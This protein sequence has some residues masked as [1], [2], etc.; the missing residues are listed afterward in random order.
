MI[1][2]NNNQA[3]PMRVSLFS[4]IEFSDAG[5]SA[6]QDSEHRHL[7][8]AF[9]PGMSSS[10]AQL[11]PNKSHPPGLSDLWVRYYQSALCCRLVRN[12]LYHQSGRCYLYRPSCRCYRS[13]QYCPYRQLVRSHRLDQLVLFPRL[14]Q[15]ARSRRYCLSVPSDPSDLKDLK[16][17]SVRRAQSVPY[18]R[19]RRTSCFG[20]DGPRGNRRLCSTARWQ[21]NPRCMPGFPP[22]RRKS[23]DYGYPGERKVLYSSPKT[24]GRLVR[25]HGTSSSQRWIQFPQLPIRRPTQARPGA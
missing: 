20:S 17:R 14:G 18:R 6:H 2:R 3:H 10:L 1:L 13:L 22:D 4:N 24:Y 11:R 9:T 8:V 16:D 23:A 19:W 7:G 21:C 25:P 5:G 12:S 15:W